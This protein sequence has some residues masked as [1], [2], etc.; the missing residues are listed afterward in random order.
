MRAI[1]AA[2]VILAGSVLAGAA[3]VA[4][5]VA[6]NGNHFAGAPTGFAEFGGLVLIGGGLVLF[7]ADVAASLFGPNRQSEPPSTHIPPAPRA[8]R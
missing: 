1:G 7:A 2:I 5:E 8:S 6:K 4:E 3:V